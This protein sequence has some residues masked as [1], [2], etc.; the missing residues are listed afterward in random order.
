MNE[1]DLMEA[2]APRCDD[3]LWCSEHLSGL[4]ERV[5]RRCAEIAAGSAGGG[6]AAKAILDAFGLKA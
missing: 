3:D 6:V 2:T 4:I 1:T 5:A